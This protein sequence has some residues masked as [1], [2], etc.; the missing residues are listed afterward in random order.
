M[1]K[2]KF[3][4]LSFLLTAN[5]N[6][7]LFVLVVNSI[8]TIIAKPPYLNQKNDKDSDKT[9]WSIEEVLTLPKN[10]KSFNGTWFKGKY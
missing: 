10:L 8:A 5:N 4:L 7:F 2:I 9:S 3:K 6:W 1:A